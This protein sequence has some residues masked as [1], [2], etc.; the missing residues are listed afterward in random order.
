M[1]VPTIKTATGRYL[2]LDPPQA[3]EPSAGV[4][5]G[6]ARVSSSDQKDDLERQ[7]GRLALAAVERGIVLD[8]VV[9][10]VGSG[11]NASRPKFTKLLTDPTVSTILVEHSDRAARFGVEHLQAALAAHG[12]SIVVVDDREIDDD[13]V[14][15]L[16]DILTSF[17]ARLYG[18][19]SA[20]HRAHAAIA[21]AG[22]DHQGES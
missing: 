13:L 20:S 17:C 19:R 8:R 18:R 11:L 7:A 15:D 9:T 12:R 6:Y 5:V 3:S 21:A 16:T 2:V 14:R 10:E 1:P 4:A 22:A